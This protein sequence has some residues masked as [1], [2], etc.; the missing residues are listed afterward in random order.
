MKRREFLRSTGS[1]AALGAGVTLL[2][3]AA[4]VKGTPANNKVNLAVIGCGGRGNMLV[5]DFLLRPD[6]NMVAACDVNHLKTAHSEKL[7]ELAG[8]K[9][10]RLQDYR[11]VL[12]DKNIDAIVNA[13]PNH[14]HAPISIAACQAGKD[15]YTEKPL[16]Y[17]LWEGRQMIAAAEKYKRVVQHGTQN[18]SAA[19]LY[20]AKKYI[21]EGKLGKIHFAR[22]CNM[23]SWPNFEMEPTQPVPSTLD[24]DL[25]L[26]PAKKRPYSPTIYS[27]WHFFWDYSS[28]D[29]YNDSIHQLDICRWLTGVNYPKTVYST[30][31]NFEPGAAE[32]PDTQVAVYEFDDMIFNFE[33]TLYTP[34]M[35]KTDGYVR[36]H[37]LIPYWL[38]NATRVELYGQNGLMIIG[39]MGGGWE[40]YIRPK[41]RK[42]VVKAFSYG[43][44]SDPEH[45]ENFIQ[46][47]RTRE[48]TNA[49]LDEAFKSTVLVW[50]AT[51]SYRLGGR[52]LQID[53]KTG[54]ILNCPEAAPFIKRESYRAPFVIPE[55]I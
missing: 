20:A 1:A 38:Q 47:I 12:D 39:R 53:S 37:D 35:L 14:W 16:C 34:Y 15:V 10:K 51:T 9:L 17:N 31:S 29:L 5:H 44:F 48:R 8:Q 24:W 19:Y 36:D 22:I 52:K 55:Q 2:T 50:H 41:D 46:C 43:R 45:K 42:P 32:T 28:G 21:E 27:N 54:D 33:L 11:Q 40:V 49:P 25:W 26:G 7:A 13:T 30:G 18:R 4:S 23:K 6:I 3:S